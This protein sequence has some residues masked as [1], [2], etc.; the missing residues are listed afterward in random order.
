MDKLYTYTYD[1]KRGEVK[2]REY[3]VIRET[4]L[5]FTIRTRIGQEMRV[6]KTSLGKLDS[7]DIMC[8]DRLDE[9]FYLHALIEHQTESVMTLIGMIHSAAER[10]EKMSDLLEEAE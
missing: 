3:P 5:T 6:R 10:L 1:F 8:L 4:D 7:T 2:V 9:K